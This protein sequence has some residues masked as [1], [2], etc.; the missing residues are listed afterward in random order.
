MCITK[1]GGMGSDGSVDIDGRELREVGIPGTVDGK[2]ED[3]VL[4]RTSHHS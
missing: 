3:H 1:G 2:E 4:L